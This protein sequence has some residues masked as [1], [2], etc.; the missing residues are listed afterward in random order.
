MIATDKG[1][2]KKQDIKITGASTLPSDEVERMVK[3]AEKNAEGAAGGGAR[4]G[5]RRL[6]ACAGQGGM[7]AGSLRRAACCLP[8]RA[9]CHATPTV[10]A[11]STHPAALRSPFTQR[12]APATS[13]ASSCCP[14]R[15]R[16]RAT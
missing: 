11:V 2:G 1:T 15:T 7:L 14:Q 6:E 3:D 4:R 12:R 8:L 10:H 5:G 13:L 16:R 9:H